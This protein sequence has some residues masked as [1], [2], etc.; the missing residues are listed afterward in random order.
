MPGKPKKSLYNHT[1]A[2]QTAVSIKINPVGD[3]VLPNDAGHSSNP[4]PFK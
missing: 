2:V 4:L 1:Q 3:R